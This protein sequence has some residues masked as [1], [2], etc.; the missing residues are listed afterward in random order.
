M[1]HLLVLFTFVCLNIIETK[2][3]DTVVTLFITHAIIIQH[4]SRDVCSSEHQVHV[5]ILV[6][7]LLTLCVHNK[8]FIT[9][10]FQW[11]SSVCGSGNVVFAC[12]LIYVK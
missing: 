12:F 11:S 1:P 9:V 4:V 10:T 8:A 3:D 7:L 2:Q 6:Y 5:Y